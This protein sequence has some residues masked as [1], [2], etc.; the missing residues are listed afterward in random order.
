MITSRGWERY[1]V[2]LLPKRAVATSSRHID[3]DHIITVSTTCTERP[4]VT[5]EIVTI[6]ALR[7]GAR[8]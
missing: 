8:P 1:W 2:C 7:A 6:G 5:Y 3:L 4:H